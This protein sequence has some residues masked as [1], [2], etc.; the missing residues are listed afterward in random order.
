[1]STT[2]KE[3]KIEMVAGKDTE[4]TVPVKR[5][6]LGYWGNRYRPAAVR[7][8]KSEHKFQGKCDS[9]KGFVYDCFEGKQSG[10]FNLVTKEIAEYVDREY[11]YGGDIRWTIE[12][13]ENFKGEEPK[14][15][16]ITATGV[17]KRMWERRVDE[18]IKRENKLK[19]N[20][21]TAYSL[22]TGQCTEYMIAKL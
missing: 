4:A 21:P 13:L 2:N 18:Y 19:E 3:N 9:L 20:L 8:P 16:D 22:V 1:M 6:R 17:Q 7:E 11:Q 12:N 15:L 5:E 10:R 14:E